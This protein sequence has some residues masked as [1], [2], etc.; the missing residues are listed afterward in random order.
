MRIRQR[1]DASPPNRLARWPSSSNGLPGADECAHRDVQRIRVDS[2]P[3]AISALLI[4]S[5]SHSMQ[6]TCAISWNE[7]DVASMLPG[8][9]PAEADDGRR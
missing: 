6:V 8:W 3:V 4:V 9:I 2:F 1:D 7:I 5:G